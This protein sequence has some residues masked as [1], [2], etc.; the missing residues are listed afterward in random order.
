MEVKEIN[1]NDI[2]PYGKNA[3]RHDEKQI[4]NVAESIKRF[5]FVQPCVV[6]KDNVLVIGHCRLLAAKKLKLK[7]IPCVYV[8]TLTD[9]EVRQLRL[10]DN[11][12]NESDWDFDLLAEDIGELDFSGFDIDWGFPE[13]EEETE[14]VEDEPPEVDEENEPICKLGDI[15]QLGRHKLI[16]GD[17]TDRA[18]VE[19]LMDGAK[20][21][22]VFTD[23]P[24]GVNIRGGSKSNKSI[25]GDQTQV[26]IPFSFDLAVEVATKDDARFYFCGGE[27]NLSLYEKLFDKY[28]RQLPRHIIWVKNGFTLK[29]NNYHNQYEIIYFGFKPKGG[30]ADKWYSGRTEEEASDVWKIKRDA[31]SSYLHPTQK[32]IELSAR[33]IRNSSPIGAIIYDPFGGS[34]STLIACEQLDRVCYMAEIDE[35]YCDVIIKRWENFTGQKAVKIS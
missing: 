9:D 26:A 10:L 19:R 27:L 18:T 25:A 8:D 12:L 28:L 7:T 6:D 13:N 1:I 32:P 17:S 24:Y 31:P 16:C 4:D 34:G 35:H 30:G 33:A 11:K 29:P 5:G 2:K 21:D 22:M 3:K 20:A 14:I 15:W 23:P